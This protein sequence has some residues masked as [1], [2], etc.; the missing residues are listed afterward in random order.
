MHID[1]PPIPQIMMGPFECL[2]RLIIPSRCIFCAQSTIEEMHHSICD[3]CLLDLKS[4]VSKIPLE[5]F[6]SGHRLYY[7]S[8]YTG[9]IKKLVHL[10][11]YKKNLDILFIFKDLYFQVINTLAEELKP[12]LITYI[13]VHAVKRIF[14]RG[15]DQNEKLLET[16]LDKV[17]KP[18]LRKILYRK[19]YTR[20]L[21]DLSVDK[22]QI[23]LKSAFCLKREYYL[24]HNHIIIFDDIYTSG[25]TAREAISQL[26]MRSPKK[27]TLV[28]LCHGY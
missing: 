6:D 1:K 18:K 25:T 16:L 26:S 14:I 28:S 10:L 2:S 21:Y 9:K 24:P 5:L 8:S 4:S 11:K 3:E 7:F 13:P 19:K 12:D 22:R 17:Q 15:F 20:P 23:E 27:I